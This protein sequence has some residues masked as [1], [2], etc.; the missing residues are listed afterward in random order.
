MS[1]MSVVS[2]NSLH[3]CM[4][5]VSELCVPCVCDQVMH[6]QVRGEAQA[7]RS[8][9]ETQRNRATQLEQLFQQQVNLPPPPEPPLPLPILDS[10]LLFL[11]CVNVNVVMC[12]ELRCVV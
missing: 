7:L 11:I 3:P 10:C 9:M 4:Q 6:L 1:H 2:V 12:Q 8:E 5:Y